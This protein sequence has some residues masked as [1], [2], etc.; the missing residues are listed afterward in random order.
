VTIPWQFPD[1]SWH[2]CPC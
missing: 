2:S 1:G